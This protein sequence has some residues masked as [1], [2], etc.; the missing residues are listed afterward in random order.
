MFSSSNQPG[1]ASFTREEVLR[2]IQLLPCT[3]FKTN[4]GNWV[5]D[6]VSPSF[7]SNPEFVLQVLEKDLLRR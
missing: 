6:G 3:R 2:M 5:V 7:T 4:G 1:R